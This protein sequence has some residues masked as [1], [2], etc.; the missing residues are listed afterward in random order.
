MRALAALALCACSGATGTLVVQLETAP[1]SHVLD[2]VQRLR[3]TLTDPREVAEA[4][5]S[6]SGFDVALEVDAGQQAGALIVEGLDAGGALVACGQSPVFSIGAISAEIVVYMAAPRSIA[7]AP[8]ALPAPLSEVSSSSLGYGVVIAGGRETSGAPSNAIAIY[9]A[10]DHSIL[11][12]LPLPGPR[13]GIAVATGVSGG[14]YLFGGTGPDGKPSGTLWRF[15]SSAPPRGGYVTVSDNAALARA[16]QLL[17][18]IGAERFLITGTPPLTLDRGTI[19]ERSDVAALPPAG[20]SLT[21]P[22]GTAS[23]MFAGD[24]LVLLHD[25]TLE[26]L[27]TSAPTD[28]SAASLPDGRA[29]VIGGL[30]PAPLRDALV[31]DGETGAVSVIPNAIATARSRPSLAATSRYLIVA[32]GSDAAGAPIAS[33][34]VLD[35]RTLA[36]VVTLPILAR[37][38]MFAIALSNDQVLLGGGSPAS[39]QLELFTPDPP[40]L[41]R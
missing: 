7:L 31:V 15:D 34:E 20:A 12:G 37:T 8:L 11:D 33:A 14:V 9:N 17:V 1:D 13:A 24:P 25:G 6:P 32:G 38:G 5:R 29:V 23:A 35:A 22:D 10:Y 4:A 21:L 28:A 40:A 39:S 26:P 3:L 36:P 30:D 2:A 16:G 41:D 19:A 18:P 27:S